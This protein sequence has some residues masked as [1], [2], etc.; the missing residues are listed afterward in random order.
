MSDIFNIPRVLVVAKM[1]C[2]LSIYHSLFVNKSLE[3][4]KTEASLCLW[5]KL[6]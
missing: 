3:C 6:L 4:Q 5:G 2:S 1:G